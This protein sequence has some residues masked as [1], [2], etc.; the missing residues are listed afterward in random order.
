MQIVC[1][2]LTALAVAALFY[3]WRDGIVRRGQREK[4]LRERITYMLWVAAQQPG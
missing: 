1:F 2:N 4:L 3:A